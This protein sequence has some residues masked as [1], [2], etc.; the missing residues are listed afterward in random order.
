MTRQMS[1]ICI[2]GLAIG[3]W[4]YYQRQANPDT[5]DREYMSCYTADFSAVSA[6]GTVVTVDYE[7]GSAVRADF[8]GGVVDDGRSLERW[9]EEELVQGFLEE[10][11]EKL[12]HRDFVRM[13][14]T[15]VHR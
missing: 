9:A 3:V 8:A 11:C 6:E 12:D 14:G 2:V 1:L 10:A 4:T 15:M 5:Q 13:G 7:L